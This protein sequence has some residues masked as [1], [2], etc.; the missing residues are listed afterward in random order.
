MGEEVRITDYDVSGGDD[1][2]RVSEWE[3]GLSNVDL[4]QDGYGR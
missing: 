2:D 4:T 1:D 3:A